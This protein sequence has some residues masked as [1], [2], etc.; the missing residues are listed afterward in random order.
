MTKNS[1]ELAIF[2]LTFKSPAVMT[3]SDTRY[4]E[5]EQE[6]IDTARCAARARSAEEKAP[7]PVE[8]KAPT[9]ENR[10]NTARRSRKRTAAPDGVHLRERACACRTQKSGET[11][12]P[13]EY[14]AEYRRNEK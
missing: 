2:P 7:R 12:S 9:A 10:G 14:T 1:E 6:S 11:G 3:K 4:V 5:H 8:T 13:A